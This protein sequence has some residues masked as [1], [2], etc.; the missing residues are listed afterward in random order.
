MVMPSLP[1]LALFSAQVLVFALFGLTVAGHFPAERRNPE[2][3]TPFGS[4][5]IGVAMFIAAVATAKAIG[6]AASRLPVYASIIG[7][8]AALLATPLALTR[9]P[10][11]FINGRAGLVTFAGLTAALAFVASKLT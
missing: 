2:L 9:F 8:G 7:C 11:W 4:L 10:D 6:L 3:R 1:I 5:L